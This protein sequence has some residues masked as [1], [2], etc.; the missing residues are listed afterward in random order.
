MDALC[1]CEYLQEANNIDDQKK[2]IGKKLK[3]TSYNIVFFCRDD[4]CH[5]HSAPRSAR[6]AGDASQ[7]ISWLHFVS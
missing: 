5:A 1:A 7:H 3:D 6:G 2:I 4:F